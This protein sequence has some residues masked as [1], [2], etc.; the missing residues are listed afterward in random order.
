LI[1]ER[2]FRPALDAERAVALAAVERVVDDVAGML[3]AERCLD[4]A[5]GHRPAAERVDDVD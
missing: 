5:P 1:Q 3:I 2:P 4:R